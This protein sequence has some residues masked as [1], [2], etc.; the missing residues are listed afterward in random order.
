[1]HLLHNN[2][3]LSLIVVTDVVFLDQL[4]GAARTQKLVEI[5]F[6]SCFQPFLFFLK[7]FDQLSGGPSTQK[8]VEIHK[9]PTL[10]KSL[11]L[12]LQGAT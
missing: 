1:M 10:A 9:R 4:S 5:L 11:Q 12:F 8:M 3:N 7:Y 6:L 2:L